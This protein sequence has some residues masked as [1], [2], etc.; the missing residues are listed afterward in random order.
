[1]R[2]PTTVLRAA[3]ALAGFLPS[4]LH[5]A[6][7]VFI[8]L[9]PEG[10]PGL[11]ADAG[12]ERN[13]AGGGVANIHHPSLTVYRPDAPNGTAVIVCPGG[14]YTYLS[15]RHE[16]IV[17]AQ[18]LNRLGVTA[19]IIKNRVKEYGQPAPLQDI[20]RA[21]RVLRS[22]AAEFGIQ[23]D[24]IGV[25]GFSAGGH[26]SASAGTLFDAAEGRTGAPLDAVSG[27]PDFMMLIY[28]VLTME[29]PYVHMGSRTNLLGPAPADELVKRWSL[30]TQVTKDS[31]PAFLVATEEDRT[32]P[33]ENSL[34]FY[35][36]LRKAGVP[37][38][39]HLYQKGAHGFGLNPGNG[40]TSEWPARAEEWMRFHGWLPT[41]K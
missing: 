10:V 16:G 31:S 1:M 22:R 9:W 24:R 37:A 17:P 13:L 26:L 19:F 35:E 7:P 5:A 2:T 15:F 34:Q 12:P 39:M 6:D 21:I 25:I 32:V 20:L 14:A 3:L 28:A 29:K 8:D 38:E 33:V 41:R 18:W 27:R 4:M 40:P 30:E 11:K 36:A 23:P